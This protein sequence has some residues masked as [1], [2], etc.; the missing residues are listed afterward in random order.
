MPKGASAGFQKRYK[1]LVKRF[2]LGQNERVY[3]VRKGDNLSSI[4]EKFNILK[5]PI[6]PGDRLIVHPGK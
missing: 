6:H 1:Q 4:A 5:Q 3:V 2:S